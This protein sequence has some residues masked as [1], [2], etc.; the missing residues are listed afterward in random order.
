MIWAVKPHFINEK[1]E[2]EDDL[3]HKEMIALQS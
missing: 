3:Y 2:K 1:V